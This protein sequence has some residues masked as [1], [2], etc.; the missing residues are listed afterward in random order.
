[1][2][3]SAILILVCLLAAGLVFAQTETSSQKQEKAAQ[4]KKKAQQEEKEQEKKEQE[5]KT[6]LFQL[7]A[8]E[9]EVV[10]YIQDIM[11]PN[12]TV[13]KPELFPMSLGTSLDTALERQAGVSIQRIQEVGTATDDDSIKIRGLGSR[14]LKVTRNGRM[15]NTSG[16]AGG[17]FVDWTMIPLTNVD[18]VEVVKGVA[19]PRYGNVLGGVINLVSRRLPSDAAATELQ[20]S[21]ASF[22]SN[23]LNLFHAYKPGAVEYSVA[24][25][26]AQSDGYLKNGDLS[27]G[28]VD[29]HLGYDF[30][31][32]G[33]F[34]VDTMYSQIRK[35]FVVPNRQSNDPDDPNYNTPLD[36]DF[37]AS[38]GEYMYGGMGAYPEPGSWWE[39][40][41]WLLDFGYEQAFRD[42][43]LVRLR[44]W[45]NHGNR[46][47]YNTRASAG[48]IFHKD[49]FDDRSQGASADYQHFWKN[50][51]VTAGLEYAHL[52]DDGDTNYPDDF[53][54]TFRNEYYVGAKTLGFFLMDEI[55]LLDDT[56]TLVPGV[57]YMSYSGV[58]GP[59]GQFE[60]IPD[61]EKSG[62]APS[63]KATYRYRGD[64]LIY[65]S[66][67]RA[68]RMPTPPEHYWHYDP[69][70]AGVDTS[71]LPFQEEDGMMLQA[72]WRALLPGNTKIEISP[73]YYDIRNYIQFDLINFV[74]Y[75][76]DSAR[77]YGI[78]LELT[79][80]FRN[81]WSAFANYTFQR[82]RSRGDPFIELFVHPEDKDFDEV[83]GLPAHRANFGVQYKAPSTASVALYLQTV[84]GQKVIYNNNRLW[85]DVL[86]VRTQDAYVKVDLEG[87]YPL[88]GFVEVGLFAR[89]IL[90]QRYQE[91][92]GFPAAGRHMGISLKALF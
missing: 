66:A 78:E 71:Q 54:S 83:P 44:Y 48:R 35:G 56:L 68:L 20:V 45:R 41:K 55:R 69:D 49:F 38:D 4:T 16:V 89:N 13:V 86:R 9:I 39:K 29:L 90:D 91:R 43:G 85:N 52:I 73:Y 8:I 27:F 23:S 70:D 58:S 61:I 21:T 14:R 36:P 18:R 74:A 26:L 46:Q 5:E 67:A 37:A 25:G 19:D 81:G 32:N 76:I 1:M 10:E 65:V 7:D 47:T 31:F 40:K 92:Y 63:L 57:R 15:L 51:T 17:Y 72:G 75:N 87:R 82:S 28:N 77:I 64:N 30:D 53:R 12:M 59:S 22:G 60:L 6:K 11:V 62:W 3:K 79:H 2:R 24:V 84:S 80:H 33:R 88:A 34:T 50:H 42:S